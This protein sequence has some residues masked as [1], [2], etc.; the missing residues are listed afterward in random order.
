M[1]AVEYLQ[2]HGP[3]NHYTLVTEKQVVNNA[4]MALFLPVGSSIGWP[5]LTAVVP[6]LGAFFIS[7]LALS[8]L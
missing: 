6:D 2:S 5:S 1:K 4:E 8:Y 3:R 7:D